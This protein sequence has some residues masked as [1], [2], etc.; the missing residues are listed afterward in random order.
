MTSNMLPSHIAP[1]QNYSTQNS[2]VDNLLDGYKIKSALPYKIF[3][4]SL[5]ELKSN[6]N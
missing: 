4:I 3:S 2:N 6:A 1:S 5:I